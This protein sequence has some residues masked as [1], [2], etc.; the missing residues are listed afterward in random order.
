MKMLFVL[1]LAGLAPIACS[2]SNGSTAGDGG[3]PSIAITSPAS[4]DSVSTTTST[5]VPVVFTVTNFELMAAGT[6]GAVNDN[7][8]HVHVLVDGTACNAGGA[9]NSAFPVTGGAGSPATATAQLSKC[10]AATGTHTLKLELHRD[11]HSAVS[12]GASATVDITAT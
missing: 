6:C 5:D 1:G 2:S 9:Y 4:G 11:D 7:C 8:G 12:N 3:I 10:P